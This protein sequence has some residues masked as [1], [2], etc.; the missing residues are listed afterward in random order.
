MQGR[1]V[2]GAPPGRGAVAAA[3]MASGFLSLLSLASLL[4]GYGLLALGLWLAAGA[5]GGA[6]AAY[7]AGYASGA[8]RLVEAAGLER[9][10]RPLVEPLY[11][12]L[13]STVAVPLAPILSYLAIVDVLRLAEAVEAEHPEVDAAEAVRRLLGGREAPPSPLGLAVAAAAAPPLMPFFVDAGLRALTVAAC[14]VYEA[15]RLGPGRA[16]LGDKPC[17][18]DLVDVVVWSE[19]PWDTVNLEAFSEKWSI[20]D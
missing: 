5:A 10:P 1:P 2:T 3:A 19:S 11:A 9:P 7:F 12:S 15:V 17:R 14:A 18:P 13:A 20:Q 4:Y 8:R 16:R 6:V